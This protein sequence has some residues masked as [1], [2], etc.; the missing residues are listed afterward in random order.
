[1]KKLIRNTSN[2][3]SRDFWAAVRKSADG[4]RSAP[5]WMKAGIDLN[6][7]NYTT[8]GPRRDHVGDASRVR[9]DAE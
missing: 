1:M 6:D 5:A 7:K 8:F 3:T 2:A 9:E 4:V